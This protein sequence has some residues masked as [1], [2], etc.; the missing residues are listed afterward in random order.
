MSRARLAIDLE[1]LVAKTAN[2]SISSAAAILAR[3][4]PWCGLLA[5]SDKPADALRKQYEKANPAWVSMAR[6]AN[7]YALLVERL[8]RETP[9]AEPTIANLARLLGNESIPT[10]D[11]K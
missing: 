8:E 1:A 2:L 4:Q 11:S 9:G 5:T 10:D 6:D 7:A 3:R